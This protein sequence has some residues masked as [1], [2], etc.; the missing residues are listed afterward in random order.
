MAVIKGGI[1]GKAS[2]KIS[3]V[4]AAT[5]KNVNYVRTLV[6]PA[7]PRTVNQVA[8]RNQ[9]KA[10]AVFGEGIVGN[11]LNPYMS[12]FLRNMSGYNWFVKTNRPSFGTSPS[13]GTV[14]TTHGQ[15]F[16]ASVSSA[17]CV[18]GLVT[19]STSTALGSNGLATDLLYCCIYNEAYKN[20]WFAAAEVARSTGTITIQTG[21]AGGNT[22]DYYLTTV[23]R[24]A[25]SRVTM[26][27]NSVSSTVLY[28]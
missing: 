2:G 25:A 13:Y 10:V 8:A 15:L 18:A 23:R 14:I 22:M 27:S 16:A 26:V 11:I 5:W 28:A 6:T 7:N 24:D 9:F 20:W 21:G 17:T 1:L 4:V 19:L 3:G 12:P